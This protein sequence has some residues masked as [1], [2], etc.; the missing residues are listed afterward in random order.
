MLLAASLHPC[1]T[2]QKRQSLRALHHISALDVDEQD[3][4][5]DAQTAN[6]IAF[7]QLSDLVDGTVIRGEGN[8]CLL[9]GPRG[10]GKTSLVNKCLSELAEPPI[11]LRLSGWVQTTDRLAL[12]EMAIQLNEQ[13]GNVYLASTEDEQDDVEPNTNTTIALPPASHLPTLV[14]LLPTL[15]RPSIVILD[16]FDLFSLHPRQ[17]LL[18]CLL[19]TV[20]SCRAGSDSKGVAV[21]GLT[22]RM[23][24][25]N[26]LEK[27]VKSRFSG[28]MLRTASPRELDD[29]IKIARTI[30]LSPPPND[31]ANAQLSSWSEVWNAA[32]EKFL[33]D[34][35]V[36]AIL[37]DTFSL[38]KDVRVLSRLLMHL[39][40]HLSPKYPLLS[41]SKLAAATTAQRARP[42]FPFLHDL[43]YPCIC[44]LVAGYH[45]DS[46]G[47]PQFTFEMLYESFRNQV[48]A[49]SSAPV[50]VN[51]GSIGMMRCSRQMMMT[52]F[53]S[54]VSGHIFVP[55]TAPNSSIAKEFVKYRCVPE[56]DDIKKAVDKCGQINVK[57]WL[58]KAQ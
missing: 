49:S 37:N 34:E 1:L 29:W 23:D 18:Y 42:S 26:L 20:Q 11:V 27:R 4:V 22:T 52:A 17:S 28:R 30:L 10:S 25:V 47:Q 48:R 24:S 5:D 36:L 9:L 35:S 40:V 58:S 39:V 2:L 41:A 3:N 33:A 43:P 12:R 51:G 54:L 32:V 7:Q 44:L 16:A 31:E 15:P 45:W 19:D 50:Q 6:Q 13:T 53:E 21:I 46:A 56:R 55:T 57:K 8:S 14:S 38:T